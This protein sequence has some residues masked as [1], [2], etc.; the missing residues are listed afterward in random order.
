M[1]DGRGDALPLSHPHA[2]SSD[3]SPYYTRPAPG[4]QPG[5]LWLLAPSTLAVTWVLCVAYHPQPPALPQAQW[6]A[7]NPSHPPHRAAGIQGAGSGPQAQPVAARTAWP[8]AVRRTRRAGVS[9][10]RSEAAPPA[11]PL[12]SGP[13]DLTEG[14]PA[15]PRGWV[16]LGIAAGAVLLGYAARAFRG[17]RRQDERLSLLMYTASKPSLQEEAEAVLRNEWPV[18]HGAHEIDAT[19]AALDPH[20][21]RPRVREDV[22]NPSTTLRERLRWFTGATPYRGRPGDR[23]RVRSDFPLEPIMLATDLPF[24]A[25]MGAIAAYYNRRP[26]SVGR[27]VAKILLVARRIILAYKRKD[28]NRAVV[29]REGVVQL[30]V[31]CVKL[32]QTL[33]TRPDIIGDEAAEAL[34]V[35][36]SDNPP[37]SNAVAYRVI[38]EDLG[39][40]GPV[41]PE[42]LRLLDKAGTPPADRECLFPELSAEPVAAASIAQVQP[43]ARCPSRWWWGSHY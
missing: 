12:H 32:A 22:G 19:E 7:P 34:A 4:A 20:Q 14:P 15:L 38:A 33:A 17:R 10:P 13:A 43:F 18:G 21:P 2:L 6:A 3:A 5:L 30:G 39:W 31:V 27:R 24:D 23:Q 42:H 41:S 26:I 8:R 40:P 37:F 16:H 35:L 1:N 29:L 36:H 11:M 25:K 9:G 28:A